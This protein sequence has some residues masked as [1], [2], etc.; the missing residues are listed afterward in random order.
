MVKDLICLIPMEDKVEKELFT[1]FESVTVAT[2]RGS[3]VVAVCQGVAGGI[4]FWMLGIDGVAIWTVVM[5]VASLLPVG[6]AIIWFPWVCVFFM[7]N[8]LAKAIILLVVGV[9]FIGLIDNLLRPRLVGQR[10]KMPDYMVLL[11]TLGGL[12]YFGL[13]GFVIGPVFAGLFISCWQ[14][15]GRKYGSLGNKEL[16]AGKSEHVNSNE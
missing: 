12:T 10:T 5:I 15:M 14:I 2:I 11:S 6:S 3:L 9:G 16:L 4:I 8:E 13:S 7:N 1:R